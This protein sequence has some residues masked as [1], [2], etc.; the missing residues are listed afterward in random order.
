[1]SRKFVYDLETLK[2]CF[3][4]L[5]YDR[6]LKTY[7]IFEMS[8][9]ENDLFSLVKFYNS[10]NIEKAIGYNNLDFDSQVMEFVLKNHQSW[11]DK[12]GREIASII[13]K[14]VQNLLED[15]KYGVRP[16]HRSLSVDQIDCFKI[17]GL[18]NA[19]RVTS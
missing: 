2:G 11:F 15:F 8:E 6:L 4:A 7:R 19:A 10:E 16:P 5:F 1:M 3:I 12:N 13:Y 18:D 14:F 17:L 9:Y